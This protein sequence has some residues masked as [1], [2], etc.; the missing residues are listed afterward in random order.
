MCKKHTRFFPQGWEVRQGGSLLPTLFKIY[1]NELVRALE[2]YPA[3]GLT[4]LD[5]EVK[6][7]LFAG[8]MVLLFP[9]KEGLQQNLDLMHRFCQTW[10]LT[11]NLSKI[12]NNGGCQDH[13]YTFLTDKARRTFYGIKRNMSFDIPIWIW[14]KIL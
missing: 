3:P 9:T 14:L 5:S 10:T 6:C 1:I 13:K 11:V 8:D 4:Q 12:K 7:L 2:Q